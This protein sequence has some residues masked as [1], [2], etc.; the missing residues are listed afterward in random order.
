[1]AE[2]HDI[3]TLRAFNRAY[4]NR[5]GFLNPRLDSSP[6]TLSEAR[7]LYEL[8]HR[9]DTTG[10]ELAR[11]LRMDPGQISRTI[12][13]FMGRGLA[14]ARDDPAHGRHQL[15]SLTE[16]GRAS[17]A[18]L[19]QNTRMAVGTLLDALP[20][21]RRARLRRAAKTLTRIFDEA[22][23]PQPLLRGLRPG[24]LGLV[25]SRQAILYA[26]DYGWNAEFEALAARILAD[27]QQQY[28]PACEAAWIAEID[29]QMVGSVFLVKGD[30]PGAGKLRLLYVEP[31]AR[32][33]GIGGMLVEA[34]IDRARAVGHDRLD[35]WTNSVLGA[36]RR[37]Y[38]RAGFV[39]VDEAPHHSF[40]HDLIGQTWSLA[41]R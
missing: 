13:R 19:E 41:L 21:V 28:D 31:A 8:A 38:Q 12:K 29:G 16:Q 33:L 7:V 14:E 35:L 9:T 1:M 15:L 6:F 32:G 27:F 4:T 20:P 40:G 30:T 39:L 23:P 34:C 24:D 36:A 26:R 37:I 11:S 17:Y 3:D 25:L 2:D 10:A 22:E 5:L 18:A